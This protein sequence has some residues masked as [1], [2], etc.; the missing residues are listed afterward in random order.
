M[1]QSNLSPRQREMMEREDRILDSARSLLLN[2]GYYATTM[3]RIAE[4]SGYP[5]GTM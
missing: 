1:H 3:D 5:K 2:E 4:A